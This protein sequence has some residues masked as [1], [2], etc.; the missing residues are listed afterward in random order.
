MRL[1]ISRRMRA[2]RP[3][4]LISQPGSLFLSLSRMRNG[5]WIDFSCGDQWRQKKKRKKTKEKKGTKTRRR[6]ME[7][8]EKKREATDLDATRVR[9]SNGASREKGREKSGWK[10]QR[11]MFTVCYFVRP[12]W[13]ASSSRSAEMLDLVMS[14]AVRGIFVTRCRMPWDLRFLCSSM[15]RSS[16]SLALPWLILTVWKVNAI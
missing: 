14:Y 1:P 12:V 4:T 16:C 6:K 15:Y 7:K 13:N 8:R 9:E 3:V 5:P 2:R 10:I 11:E